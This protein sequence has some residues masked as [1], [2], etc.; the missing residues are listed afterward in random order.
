MNF[1]ELL[2]PKHIRKFFSYIYIYIIIPIFNITVAEPYNHHLLL[3]VV[4]TII[5][6]PIFASILDAK[7]LCIPHLR[8]ITF[9]V[10]RNTFIYIYIH[11]HSDDLSMST[12][13][14][15]FYTFYLS[16]DPIYYSSVLTSSTWQYLVQ[17][18]ALKIKRTSDTKTREPSENLAKE[19]VSFAAAGSRM[20][21]L[22]RFR[23]GRFRK[24]L[25]LGHLLVFF[26]SHPRRGHD[27]VCFLRR[28]IRIEDETS[29]LD[30]GHL[31]CAY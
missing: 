9:K 22:L 12:G 7:D 4:K 27:L 25:H 24:I 2:I 1:F 13:Q 30:L 26:E 29:R 19:T 28:H 10:T 5:F 31:C 14:R 21:L 8:Y 16:G 18:W 23:P 15:E 6:S 11:S 17:K 3:A 20:L